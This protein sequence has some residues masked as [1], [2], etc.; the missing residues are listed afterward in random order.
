MD[1]VVVAAGNG[2]RYI[3]AHSYSYS[4]RFLFCKCHFNIVNKVS[5][6]ISIS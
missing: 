5:C 2:G 4:D 1:T 3:Y 6:N